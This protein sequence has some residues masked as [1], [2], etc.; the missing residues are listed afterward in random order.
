MADKHTVTMYHV[1]AKVPI[2]VLPSDVGTL[3]RSGWTKEKPKT[4]EEDK[5]R[6]KKSTKPAKRGFLNG[7]K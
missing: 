1:E 4:P 3:E 5:P 6:Q 2:E 7:E